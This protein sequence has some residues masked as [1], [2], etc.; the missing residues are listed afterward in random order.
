MEE[1]SL[2]SCKTLGAVTT[3]TEGR[4]R[5]MHLEPVPILCGQDAWFYKWVQVGAWE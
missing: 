4:E 5:E 2:S 1:Y 3:E